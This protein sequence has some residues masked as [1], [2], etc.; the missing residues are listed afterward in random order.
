MNLY[1]KLKMQITNLDVNGA[2]Q[3]TI[4][5]IASLS[6]DNILSFAYLVAA[7][8]SIRHNIKASTLKIE[9]E[10]KKLEMEVKSL[11]QDS[12]RKSLENDRY[13]IETE[14]LALENEKLRDNCNN[15]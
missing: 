10:V 2:I 12:I 6:V 11:D 5:T 1:E 9:V 15:N 14:R 7:I 3:T 8:M 13:R 4:A